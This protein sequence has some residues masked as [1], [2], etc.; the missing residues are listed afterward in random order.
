MMKCFSII[1]FLCLCAALPVVAQQPNGNTTVDS[2]LLYENPALDKLLKL[3]SDVSDF[4]F[5]ETTVFDRKPMFKLLPSL[6]RTPGYGFSFGLGGAVSFYTDKT[7]L[8]LN[9][10]E[11][12]LYFSVA[13]TRPF[14]YSIGCDPVFYFASNALRLRAEISYRDWLEY[15]F[16]VGYSL[17]HAPVYGK[18]RYTYESRIMRF[19]SNVQLRL[20]GAGN[21]YGGIVA[22]VW[23][24]NVKN[25]E[26][27]VAGDAHFLELAGNDA[28]YSATGTGVGINL[29]YDSRDVPDDAYRGVYFSTEAM[30]YT[31]KFGGNVK[32]GTFVI[33]YRQYVQLRGRKQVLAWNVTSNNVFG[34]HV[35][36]MRYATI[37]GVNMFRGY[38]NYQYRDKSML[39][40]Q[41][42]YRYWLQFNSGWGVLLNRFGFAVWAGTGA[43]GTNMVRYDHLLPQAGVGVRFALRDRL[44]F[45][46]DVA[47]NPIDDDTLWYIS[48]SEAF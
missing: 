5:K 2:T 41:V 25:P 29:N 1:C 11:V 36:F 47:H 35:P 15:Y 44:N 31:T 38:Y 18:E 10:S 12:P 21:L 13:F 23:H 6:R 22:D 43:M 7:N 24:E 3:Q 16:G 34:N 26:T 48:F 14:S 33:D 32:Y 4:I 8:Q 42:E 39:T 45:R 28:S 46:F 40:A 19:K 30:L 20:A 17:N 9:R 37:G 27:F